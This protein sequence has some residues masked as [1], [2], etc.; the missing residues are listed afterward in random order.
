MSWTFIYLMFVLK[1]PIVGLFWIVWW[2]VH[3]VDDENVVVEH[4]DGSGGSAIE[5]ADRPRSPNPQP[6]RR[7][8]HPGPAPAPP[9]RSR[10]VRPERTRTVHDR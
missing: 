4:D 6:T 5:R 7:G 3:N 10:P 2:A 9:A 1:I 8:P